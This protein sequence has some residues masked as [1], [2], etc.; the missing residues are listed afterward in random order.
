MRRLYS[1]LYSTLSFGVAGC[2]GSSRPPRPEELTAQNNTPCGA[3]GLASVVTDCQ[4]RA[5]DSNPQPAKP[6]SDFESKQP[7]RGVFGECS[8]SVQHRVREQ[9]EDAVEGGRKRDSSTRPSTRDGVGESPGGYG[10]RRTAVA[11]IRCAGQRPIGVAGRLHPSTKGLREDPGEN[12]P[13]VPQD[14]RGDGCGIRGRHAVRNATGL[15]LAAVRAGV[16]AV[17]QRDVTDGRCS[18]DARTADRFRHGSR[19]RNGAEFAR[20]GRKT[21]ETAGGFR[22]TP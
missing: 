7:V 6:A 11:C 14:E 13:H 2:H 10:R 15:M 5:R 1:G 21:S 8:G 4:R 16:V 9:A 18:E 3:R 22:G 20:S 19:R 17:A 12:M